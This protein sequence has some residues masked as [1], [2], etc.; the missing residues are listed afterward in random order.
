MLSFLATLK[1]IMTIHQIRGCNYESFCLLFRFCD[2]IGLYAL[3]TVSIYEA[4]RACQ[5]CTHPFKNESFAVRSSEKRMRLS[6]TGNWFWFSASFCTGWRQKNYNSI[7]SSRRNAYNIQEAHAD[8]VTPS[9]SGNIRFHSQGN[10]LFWIKQTHKF[11]GGIFPDLCL[12]NG[13]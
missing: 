6:I 10:C 3:V 7:W 12:R 9:P 11:E 5:R 13:H 4:R 2:Y 1:F 8:T